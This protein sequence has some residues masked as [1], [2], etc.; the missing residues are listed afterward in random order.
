LS[1]PRALRHEE[2]PI[3]ESAALIGVDRG[4]AAFRELHFFLEYCEDDFQALLTS[5]R[6]FPG[7]ARLDETRMP[8]L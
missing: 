3:S 8:P 1:P 7:E 5:A 6:L 4:Y 2:R